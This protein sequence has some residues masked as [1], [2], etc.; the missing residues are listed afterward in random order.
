M[1]HPMQPSQGATA[2]MGIQQM[3]MGQQQQQQPPMN[4]V[5]SGTNMQPALPQ[6]TP[7]L[8]QMP[9]QKQNKVTP[10]AKPAGLDPVIILQERENRLS[11]RIVHRIEELSSLPTTMAEDIRMKA[12]IELRALRLLNFQRQLR[13]EVLACTRRDTT[14]ETAVNIKAYKRTKRQGLREARATEKLEKQQKLEAERR[15]RQKHQEYLTAVLQHGKELKE[16]HRNNQVSVLKYINN[17][18]KIV[19]I[20]ILYCD[21]QAKI[22]RLNKAVLL[23]HAN[24][25]REQKKEQER[26][27]KER[28]R[29]L[30]AEDEEG[31]R[32][33]I[34]Q[35][36][37][38]RLAFLLQQTDEYI[39]NLTEMVKQ[40]KTEQRRKMRE[41][42]IKRKVQQRSDDPSS[43]PA[44]DARVSVM[45][46]A[47]GNTLTG[48]D[49]PLASQ[50]Q[51]WLD[52]HPGWEEVI[53][54]GDSEEDNHEEEGTTAAKKEGIKDEAALPEEVIPEII[55][56]AKAEDDE[57]K[58]DDGEKNYYSIAHTI[59]EKVTDQATILVNGRLK[60]YQIKGLEWLVSLYN[61][62]LNGIL[63]DEMGLGKTIQ[64][65]ALITYLM[66]AKKNHGPFL[67][68]VPL[69]T[70]SN[71][72]LEFEKWAPS[73][74]VV[75]YKGSPVV[76]RIVQN[77][78]RAVKFNV[79]LT[80]YE[81]VIKDKSVLAKLPFKY[82]IIDE[83]HRMKNHHCKLTQVMKEFTPIR[84][85]ILF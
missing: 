6:Q 74:N 45:E 9:P 41:Q 30:M 69:S 60:E 81:Y 22:V 55:Q 58:T 77:Q 78:M 18:L 23:Y 61:N 32:K 14:L 27:E 7:S 1:Q 65:I 80:T 76:R 20:L 57:Y 82:M 53:E 31:Y 48:E 39:A 29:R 59:H 13:A 3:N 42:R 36:K 12:Q 8:P 72:S 25:E 19:Y 5:S 64:T 83:G 66:E 15:R 2:P 75:C 24:A 28:M 70:L 26:I 51:A 67:I 56:K 49:A 37:D 63:A 84:V 79:L 73:V 11:A 10:V 4:Q 52:A 21:F 34:D 47:T 44:P 62:N 33:L 17:T 46:T 54:D 50:L 16:F 68:I 85:R 38:K 71:W 35:K 43:G 40:H